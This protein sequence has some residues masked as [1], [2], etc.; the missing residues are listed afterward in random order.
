[1]PGN[2]AIPDFVTGD[3]TGVAIPAHPEAMRAAPEAFLTEAMRA[4]GMLADNNRVVRVTRFEPFPGGNSGQK[5]ILSVEYARPEPG[6]PTELFA[7]FSRDFGDPFRDRRRMELEAEVRLA[8]LSR[9]PAFPVHVA[10]PCFADFNHETGTGLLVTERIAFGSGNIEPLHRKCM[11][12][13]MADPLAHYE[14]IVSALA[15]LAA[16]HKSGKLSPDLERLFPFDANAASADLPIE[17]DEQ[18]L[19]RKVAAWADFAASFPQLMPPSLRE[20]GFFARM[21]RDALALLRHE[22]DVRRFLH[23][24][25]DFVALCHW[26][27]NIDNAWFWRDEHG[28]LRCGLLDWGMVRQ[29]NVCV[30]LWG[31]LSASEPDFL[32]ANLDHLLDH[33]AAE[34]AKNGGPAVDRDE[35]AL[36]FN[37]SLAMVGLALMMDTPALVRE[38]MPDIGQARG[39]HD[40]L[41]QTEQVVHGFLRVSTNFLKLWSD[42]DFGASLAEMLAR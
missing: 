17:L 16:A 36:H 33:F 42:R 30:G 11:D 8:S 26:N 7:K 25:P 27:T 38:R 23:S 21:E 19:R 41:L 40:P 6:L 18:Q 28:A 39:L 31:G 4:Y 13:E 2:P 24:D 32:E 22:S 29:M 37:L 3:N 35:L 34:L 1:M 10:R 15:E 9:H 12:H 14:A 20:S 5:L